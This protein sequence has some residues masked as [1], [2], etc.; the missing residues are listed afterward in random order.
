MEREASARDGIQK[1]EKGK[2]KLRLYTPHVIDIKGD[3]IHPN[4]A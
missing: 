1:R 3:N 2:E 4:A